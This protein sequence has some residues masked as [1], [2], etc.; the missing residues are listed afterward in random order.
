[1]AEENLSEDISSE[2]DLSAP[3]TIEMEDLPALEAPVSELVLDV[4]VPQEEETMEEPLEPQPEETEEVAVS[5]EE[6][7]EVELSEDD[8]EYLLK[9]LGPYDPRKDLEHYK[10]PSLNLLKVYDNET[11]P[12]INQEEQHANAIRIQTTLRN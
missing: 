6:I 3:I 2:D 1:M 9:K 11:A 5:V 12:V 10:F 7:K 8:P 4:E